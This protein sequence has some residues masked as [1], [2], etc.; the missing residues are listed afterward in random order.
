MTNPLPL[1]TQKTFN[2]LRARVLNG[3]EVTPEEY[4]IVISVLRE[5]REAAATLAKKKTPKKKHTLSDQK[6][7]DLFDEL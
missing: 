7:S 6:V 4:R 3:E 2:D 5:G 1:E